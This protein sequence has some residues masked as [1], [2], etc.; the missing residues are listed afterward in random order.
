MITILAA[1]DN[2]NLVDE[3]TG[4]Q[5]WELV[6]TQYQSSMMLQR[7]I[8]FTIAIIVVMA[9]LRLWLRWLRLRKQYG[10]L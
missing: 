8:I 4:R 9:A 7:V 6:S 3:V 10:V 1:V 2:H 5:R